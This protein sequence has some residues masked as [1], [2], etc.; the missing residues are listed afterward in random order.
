MAFHHVAFATKDPSATHAFYTEVMGFRLVKV[1]VN[2]TPDDTGWA[3]HFFYDT[4]DG[5]MIAFWDI[6]DAKIGVDYRTDI[7]TGMGLPQWVNHLAFDAPDL[8]VLAAH[9]ERWR[10]CGITVVEV[11]HD[12]CTSIYA[13]DPN[14]I[15]VEFCCTTRDF[16]E[17]E[18]AAAESRLFG[19]HPEHDPE[20]KI[21]FYEPAVPARA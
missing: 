17:E 7:S 16:S 14:G 1:V 9:R 15:M 3:R 5:Q 19:E 10:A 12:F 20:P 11:D 18:K 2:P 4:G 8:G 6:H 13:T 21:T